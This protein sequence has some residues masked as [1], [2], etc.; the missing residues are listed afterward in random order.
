M[1][2]LGGLAGVPACEGCVCCGLGGGEEVVGEAG[3]GAVDEGADFVGLEDERGPGG[4]CGLAEGDAPAGQ[5]LGFDAGAAVGAAPWLLPAVGAEAG[6]G[7]A[8]ADRVC[9]HGQ[10]S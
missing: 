10:V 1:S 2:V 9:V 5:F 3:F 8:V 4:V 7:Y 6:S